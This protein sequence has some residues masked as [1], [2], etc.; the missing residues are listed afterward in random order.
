MKTFP[1]GLILRKVEQTDK[2]PKKVF[3]LGVYASAVH[4]KW[5]DEEN[6]VKVKAM[7][8]ASEP[9]IFWKGDGADKIIA[10]IHIPEELGHLEPADGMFNGPSG[11]V[12]DEKFLAPLGLTRNDVWLSD[13]IPYTRINP[14]QRAA[15]K[16]NYDP[17]VQ[18]YF[19][20]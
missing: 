4:A 11:N 15:L 18:N 1:F 16:K 5:I 9:Y 2:S 19:L 13:I 7:A 14:S 3:I 6:K 17:F 8:V 10:D 20:P 12:L